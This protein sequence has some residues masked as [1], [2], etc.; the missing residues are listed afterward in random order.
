MFER[1][2]EFLISVHPKIHCNILLQRSSIHVPTK[3]KKKKKNIYIKIN[4]ALAQ[5]LN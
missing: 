2:E 5:H 1:H 3:V 4:I